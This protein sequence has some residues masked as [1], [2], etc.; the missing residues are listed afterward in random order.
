LESLQSPQLLF[1]Q[2]SI[3]D[4]NENFNEDETLITDPNESKQFQGVQMDK[5]E[6][7]NHSQVRDYFTLITNSIYDECTCTIVKEIRICREKIKLKPSTILARKHLY[8][9]Y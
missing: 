4:N 5:A 6:R 8:M 7:K 3:F 9:K 2:E 1:N